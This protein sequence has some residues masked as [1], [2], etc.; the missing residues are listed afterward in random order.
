MNDDLNTPLA[1]SVLFEMATEV[2]RSGCAQLAGRLKALAGVL[3]LL[4]R[5]G[6]EFS[7]AAI[8]KVSALSEQ[9]I[10][11][12][13]DQRVQAKADKDF[14]RADQIR[15]DLLEQGVALEDSREGTKWRRV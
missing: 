5:T 7:K 14:V 13:I 3:G 11:A 4:G 10:Q 9:E 8:G 15:K 1:V 12:F 2:N 6:E